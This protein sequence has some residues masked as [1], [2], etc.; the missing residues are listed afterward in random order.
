M[1]TASFDREQ[2]RETMAETSG[3]EETVQ[4][5]SYDSERRILDVVM[6]SGERIR[7]VGVPQ[8]RFKLLQCSADKRRYFAKNIEARCEQIL[9]TV[10]AGV[11][12]EVRE[13]AV[14]LWSLA[15]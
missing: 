9:H 3:S 11:G 12:T 4:T 6:S 1:P 15:G 2:Q 13:N 5:V 8:D 7:F 10:P 14:V